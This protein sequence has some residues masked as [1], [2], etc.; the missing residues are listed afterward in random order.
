V[1]HNGR[2]VLAQSREKLRRLPGI[3]DPVAAVAD[4]WQL[5]AV[6]RVDG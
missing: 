4:G 1:A 3:H 5:D 2:V 6:A